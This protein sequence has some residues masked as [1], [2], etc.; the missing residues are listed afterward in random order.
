MAR[1]LDANGWNVPR[2]F[3]YNDAGAQIDNLVISVQARCNGIA[4]DDARFPENGYRGDYIMDIANSFL[5]KETVTAD[6]IQVTASG[7]VND[8][9]SVR[10]FSVAYLRHE[11]DLDL[12]AFQ[13]KFVLLPLPCL[14]CRVRFLMKTH[15]T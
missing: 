5:A 11:Q 1:L 10:T 7:D 12:K 15:Q 8:V 9:E 4:A 6:D 2:E 3:Y 13:I 14:Y